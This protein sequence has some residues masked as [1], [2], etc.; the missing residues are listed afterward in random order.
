MEGYS[1]SCLQQLLS[2]SLILGL[3]EPVVCFHGYEYGQRDRV[4]DGPRACSRALPLPMRPRLSSRSLLSS[5]WGLKLGTPWGLP[6]ET[7]THD[8]S[9]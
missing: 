5:P 9:F 6:E 1:C 7:V 8:P 4:C 3:E 2:F